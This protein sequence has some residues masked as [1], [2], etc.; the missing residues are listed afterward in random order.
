VGKRKN[1]LQIQ[2]MSRTMTDEELKEDLAKQRAYWAKIRSGMRPMTCEDSDKA[3]ESSR[4]QKAE[5]PEWKSV[6]CYPIS[7]E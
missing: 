6:T 1:K 2:L 7:K 4:R 3:F 5:H